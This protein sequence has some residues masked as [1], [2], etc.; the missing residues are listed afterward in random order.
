MKLSDDS[1]TLFLLCSHVGPPGEPDAKPLSSKEWN[2]LEQQLAFNSFSLAELP[3]S[4]AE[5]IKSTLN[6]AIVTW[7]LAGGAR[8]GD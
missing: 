7:E 8:N 6:S 3:G 2:Q 5:Q 4:T 1:Y